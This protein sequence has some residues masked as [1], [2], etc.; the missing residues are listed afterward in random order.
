MA[1]SD[2]QKK[3]WNSCVLFLSKDGSTANLASIGVAVFCMAVCA[4]AA[5]AYSYYVP[6]PSHNA[7]S[8]NP[9]KVGYLAVTSLATLGFSAGNGMLAEVLWPLLILSFQIP[10]EP[11]V[12]KNAPKS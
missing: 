7:S 12:F 8:P 5:Y 1:W 11:D 3:E 10:E 9:H 6:F 2:Q 4:L